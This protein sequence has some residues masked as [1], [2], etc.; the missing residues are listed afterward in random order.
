MR[1]LPDAYARAKASTTEESD[2]GNSNVRACAG[3]PGNRRSYR[4]RHNLE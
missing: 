1:Y 3:V 2:E 4:E